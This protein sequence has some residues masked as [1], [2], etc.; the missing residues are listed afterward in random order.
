MNCAFAHS[1][2][3]PSKRSWTNPTL[4]TVNTSAK[5]TVQIRSCFGE[6]CFINVMLRK[7]WHFFKSRCEYSISNAAF[8]E[9][10]LSLPQSFS[11]LSF[12]ASLNTANHPHP[13][14]L[15]TQ[16]ACHDRSKNTVHSSSGGSLFLQFLNDDSSTCQSSFITQSWSPEAWKVWLCK[17]G[18]GV[19]EIARGHHRLPGKLPCRRPVVNIDV[20]RSYTSNLPSEWNFPKDKE[21]LIWTEL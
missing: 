8:S 18:N 11:Q 7:C 5:R 4:P 2:E 6:F 16:R 14:K 21:H 9:Q 12:Q 19:W 20:S 13:C 17:S 3:Q 10:V 1:N 15:D